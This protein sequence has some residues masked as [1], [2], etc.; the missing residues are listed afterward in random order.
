[1]ANNVIN[2]NKKKSVAKVI[3]T[4]LECKTFADGVG[5]DLIITC[6]CQVTPTCSS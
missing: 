1:M 5:V 4:N 2:K 3:G 6:S